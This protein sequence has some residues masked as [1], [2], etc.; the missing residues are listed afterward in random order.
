MN[1]RVSLVLLVILALVG[2]YVFLFELRKPEE[3]QLLPPWFYDVETFEIQHI[4]IAHQGQSMA[5]ARG[6]DQKWYF[7]DG[8]GRPV[9]SGKFSGMT[10]LLSGPRSQRELEE[11]DLE[12]ASFGLEPPQTEITVG[13]T[14]GRSVSVELGDVTPAGDGQYARLKRFSKIFVVTS[15]WG[16][17]LTKLVTEPPYPPT[18]TPTPEGQT[19]S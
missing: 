6:A 1:V 10:L 2:S 14:E 8:T 12:P 19:S 11:E 15:S 18:P 5:Y 17:V 4:N 16:E 9:D 3:A 13:L 7:D